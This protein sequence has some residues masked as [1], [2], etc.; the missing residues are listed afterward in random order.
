MYRH[1]HRTWLLRS[2]SDTR[3][4]RRELRK[5]RID[6][7]LLRTGSV[8]ARYVVRRSRYLQ[9]RNLEDRSYVMETST[10]PSVRATSHTLT[11]PPSR[12]YSPLGAGHR[13]S[14]AT[15]WSRPDRRLGRTA[16]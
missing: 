5:G 4:H 6:R 12:T 16:T 9:R 11:S 7:G 2:T 3:E 8:R 10:W 14:G 15:A 1:R 13:S